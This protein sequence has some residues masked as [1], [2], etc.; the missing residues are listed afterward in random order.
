MYVDLTH[1]LVRRG[2]LGR[3]VDPGTAQQRRDALA[4]E[5]VVVR[6]HDSHGISAV[7][8]VPALGRLKIRSV[9]WSASTRSAKPRKP[10]PPESSAPPTPSSAISILASAP[11]RHTRIVAE[12]AFA[13]FATLASA[14]HATKYAASSTRSGSRPDG[15][16]DTVVGTVD[17]VASESS[18]APRPCSSTAGWR[19]RASSR[20]SLS[21]RASSPPAVF[22]SRSAT[23]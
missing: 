21:D 4:R 18:A 3:H 13:Y 12:L 16:N 15:S 6:D 10:D 14:S 20:S 8:T 17:R 2:R 5:Q 23:S 1:E 7:T 11:D 9:P 22:T 19:P